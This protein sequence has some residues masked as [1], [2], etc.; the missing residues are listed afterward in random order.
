MQLIDVTAEEMGVKKVFNPKENILAGSKYL[1]KMIDRFGDIKLGLA[2][3]NA[4]AENVKKYGDIPPFA[5]TREYV[6]KVLEN[7]ERYQNNSPM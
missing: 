1:K 3:Y 6:T 5:E 4:G 7:M 2:A